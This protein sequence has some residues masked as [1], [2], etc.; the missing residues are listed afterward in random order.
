[1]EIVALD[2]TTTMYHV[3]SSKALHNME[4]ALKIVVSNTLARKIFRCAT[5]VVVVPHVNH[6]Q[7]YSKKYWQPSKK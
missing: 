4:D 5:V 2:T 1:L 7:H 6:Q 3:P